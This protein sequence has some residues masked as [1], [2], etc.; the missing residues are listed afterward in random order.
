MLVSKFRASS[1]DNMVR[2]QKQE[3]SIKIKVG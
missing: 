3:H 1:D 2:G